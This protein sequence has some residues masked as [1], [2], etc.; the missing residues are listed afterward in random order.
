M[1]RKNQ[2]SGFEKKILKLLKSFERFDIIYTFVRKSGDYYVIVDLLENDENLN[3]VAILTAVLLSDFYTVEKMKLIFK[4]T[5]K[6]K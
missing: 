6:Y 2:K 5:D 3:D 1:K 4:L